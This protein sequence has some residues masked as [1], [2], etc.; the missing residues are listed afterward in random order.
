M[1]PGT[2]IIIGTIGIAVLHI[3]PAVMVYLEF[4][5]AAQEARETAERAK[6][7]LADF[8]EMQEHIRRALTRPSDKLK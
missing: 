2:V 3:V 8:E 4:R 6:R 1:T 5:K 7:R